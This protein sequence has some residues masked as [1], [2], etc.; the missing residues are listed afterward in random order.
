MSIKGQCSDC[1]WTTRRQL[2]NMSR[3]CPKCGGAVYVH[4]EDRE[5]AITTAVV[6]AI[7]MIA[8]AVLMVAAGGAEW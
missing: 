1:G 6:T 3:P 4:E 8:V 7:A 2:R 5:P